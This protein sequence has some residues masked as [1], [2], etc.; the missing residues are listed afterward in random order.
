MK[1]QTFEN[2]FLIACAAIFGGC[3]LALVILP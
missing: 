2:W 3:V 1:A